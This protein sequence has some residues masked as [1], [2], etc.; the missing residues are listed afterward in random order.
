MR[1]AGTVVSATLLIQRHDAIG[2][3]SIKLKRPPVRE[4]GFSRVL[5]FMRHSKKE[6]PGLTALHQPFGISDVRHPAHPRISHNHDEIGPP[7][8]VKS[9]R[10]PEHAPKRHV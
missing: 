3:A 10:C 9:G 7:G 6:H 1:T 8:A 2:A 5:N 4:A